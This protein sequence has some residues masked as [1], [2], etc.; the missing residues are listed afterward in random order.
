MCELCERLEIK[1]EDESGDFVIL[2][3]PDVVSDVAE[4]KC[5]AYI[6]CAGS[7]NDPADRT[8]CMVFDIDEKWEEK[9]PVSVGHRC[10]FDYKFDNSFGCNEWFNIEFCPFCG[11]KLDGFDSSA[12]DEENEVG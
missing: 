10:S 11:R 1:E 7:I 3:G 8:W 2:K 4:C 6:Q 9:I 5:S 12:E